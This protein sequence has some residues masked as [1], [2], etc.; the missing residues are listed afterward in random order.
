MRV[1]QPS[2]QLHE[3]GD[4]ANELVREFLNVHK[5]DLPMPSRRTR[6]RWNPP[7]MGY[8]KANVDVALFEGLDF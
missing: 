7:P 4:Q 5:R 2:W 3:I 1:H 6:A 8:Y